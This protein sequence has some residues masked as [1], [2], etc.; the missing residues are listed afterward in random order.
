MYE[1]GNKDDL[2]KVGL[3]SLV[4]FPTPAD[5]PYFRIIDDI[6][7]YNVIDNLRCQIVLLTPMAKAYQDKRGLLSNCQRGGKSIIEQVKAGKM[8]HFTKFG[9]CI[10]HNY[11]GIPK[12]KELPSICCP[13][14]RKFCDSC[15]EYTHGEEDCRLPR[16]CLAKV[17][18]NENWLTAPVDK[19][20][21]SL[22]QILKEN[23]E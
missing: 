2:E 7:S 15:G 4:K 5:E 6:L 22:I 14:E 23:K 11:K 20:N 9:S 21:A 18:F 8:L 17:A 19:F 10:Y 13:D 16:S 3:A 1:I 12:P